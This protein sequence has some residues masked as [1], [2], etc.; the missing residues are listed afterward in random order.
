ME[1]AR[2]LAYLVSAVFFILGLKQL[3]SP[4]TARRGNLLAVIGMA[5]AILVTLLDQQIIDYTFIIVG[6]VVGSAIG[7]ITA[8]RVQMTSMPQMVAIFNGF[9]GGA[10]AL[11]SAQALRALR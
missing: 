2:N 3:G 4:R 1:A 11:A 10:S 5:I 9:G 8:R 6:I 7:A